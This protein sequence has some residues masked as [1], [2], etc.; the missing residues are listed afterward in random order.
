MQLYEKYKTMFNKFGVN[1]KLRIA[2]FMAQAEHE[3]NLKPIEENLNYSASG[4]R[5]IFKKYFSELESIKYQRKPEQIA[6]I[7]YANRM[8]NGDYNS[9]DGWKYR[10]RGLFQITGKNNY[11]NLSKDVNIDYVTNPDLLLNEADSVIAALWFWQKNN[12]NKYADAEDVIGLTRK[13]NGGYNGL[14][15]R[16]ELTNK[17]KGIV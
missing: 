16:V 13:I 1:T 7:V 9:G 10:G 11:T 6:N 5:K 3:S 17:W 12:L 8:G 2:Y 4:L 15:H 14:A